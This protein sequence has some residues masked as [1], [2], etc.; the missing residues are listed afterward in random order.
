M[1]YIPD[2]PSTNSRIMAT[3]LNESDGSTAHQYICITS[4]CYFPDEP[5]T[6]SRVMTTAP[7]EADGHVVHLGSTLPPTAE[8]TIPEDLAVNSMVEVLGNPPKY[9]LIRWIGGLPESKDPNKLVAGLEMASGHIKILY[10]YTSTNRTIA[11][12]QQFMKRTCN[13][14]NMHLVNALFKRK[15]NNELSQ[16]LKKP[17]SIRI[18]GSA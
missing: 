12:K 3:A 9:G 5:S 11:Y 4:M 13:A 1:C 7:N 14:R 2:N 10:T 6:N 15:L 16:A 18:V 17:R 8:Y